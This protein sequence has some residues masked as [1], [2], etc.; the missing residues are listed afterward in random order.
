MRVYEFGVSRSEID[1]L[2]SAVAHLLLCLAIAPCLHAQKPDSRAA[3]GLAILDTDIGDDIDDA[4]A[5]GLALT[6]P[7]LRLIGI[8]SAWGDTALRTRMIDRLLCETGREDIPVATGVATHRPGAAAFSQAPWARA[9]Q[10][11]PKHHE[12]AVTFL[13]DQA[14][15]HPGEITLIA[16]APLTNLGAA[17]DRDPATFRKFKR[18]VM[19]GGSVYRGY[20]ADSSPDAEYN[21][22]M[23]PTAA[24]KLFHSGVPIYM[25]PLD[26]T[27]IAFDA[28]RS[29]QFASISTPLTDTIEVLTAEWSHETHRNTPTLFDPVAV[30]FAAAAATCPVTP[31]HIEIDGQGFT[32]PTPGT[33]NAQVCLQPRPEAFFALLMPRL[34]G[35]RLSGTGSCVANP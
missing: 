18:V 6:S 23:D 35:Q 20:D 14:K 8:T 2:R 12:D 27:Q 4:F 33:P 10:E 24:R 17:I 25:M 32:R 26:S 13:L 7:E 34:L 16:I 5:L 29:S 11:S 3:P 31:V 15:K 1:V 19:M 9:G 21:I 30:A 28:Q 22:A